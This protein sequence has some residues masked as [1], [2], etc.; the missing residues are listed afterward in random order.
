MRYTR[1]IATM[2]ALSL[3][4]CFAGPVYK[5]A[6]SDHFD[7]TSF[8]NTVSADKSLWAL[9][10][11]AVGA[12]FYSESWPQH[13]ASMPQKPLL[14]QE[15]HIGVTFIN[16]ST[17]LLQV[18]GVN[19]LTDSMYIAYALARCHLRGCAACERLG[20][21]ST[22]CRQLTSFSSATTTM[23]TLI[24]IPCSACNSASRRTGRSL[25]LV[26]LG[27][28]GLLKEHG[29]RNYRELD[30]GQMVNHKGLRL[31]FSECRHR[32]GRGVRDQ[33]KTLW[34][35]FVVQGAAGNIYFAGDT[36]YGPHFQEARQRYGP[37]RLAL[38]P[39]G[40]YEPRW[41]MAAVHLNPAEAGKAH[42]DL[43][44]QQS[45]AIHFGTFQLTY[46]GIDQPVIDLRKALRAQ[47]LDKED[48]WVLDFGE[49]RMLN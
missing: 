8:T 13:I 36:G 27:V 32:S 30:W 23:T 44:S 10:Q 24:S 16:H 5:G 21:S 49:T 12:L 1:L 29:F 48:F 37:F 31:I 45:V 46:E 28:G 18:D 19:I 4:G 17:V 2:V 39:I 42:L 25:L 3:A 6:K 33:M 38:L 34:G 11:L 40:A 9:V 41:F 7:G 22:I 14:V 47:A 43:G 20:C 15:P 26:G 35:S